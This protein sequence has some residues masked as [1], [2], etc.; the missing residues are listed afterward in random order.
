M[1]EA[2]K[3]PLSITILFSS[4]ILGGFYYASEI[5]KQRSIEH[6]LE[7][8]LTEERRVE[9]TKVNEKAFEA[10]VRSHCVEVAS[11]SASALY[12]DYCNGMPGCIYKEGVFL[13]PQ[14]DHAYATCLQSN[15]LK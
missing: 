15:G 1:S 10:E 13:R 8:K 12:K 3:L 7:M 6:Q 2:T 9:E 11:V 5:N 4:I 14:Y